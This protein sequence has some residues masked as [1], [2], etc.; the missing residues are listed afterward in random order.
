[1][2]EGKGL[3]KDQKIEKTQGPVSSKSFNGTVVEVHSGDSLSVLHPTKNE[4]VRV[5]FPNSRAPSLSQPLGFEAKELLRKRAIGQDVRV[6]IEFSKR[7][8]VKRDDGK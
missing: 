2:K 3:W 4:A 6:D 7:I 8:N 5:F 1:M